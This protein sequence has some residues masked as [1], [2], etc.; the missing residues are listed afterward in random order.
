MSLDFGEIVT[1]ERGV[2]L[3]NMGKKDLLPDKTG[4]CWG[5]G[6]GGLIIACSTCC[7]TT[8]RCGG[9]GRGG[10]II[11]CS[12]CSPTTAGC[13]GVGGGLSVFHVLLN[14]RRVERSCFS[15]TVGCGVGGGGLEN[16]MFHVLLK[17]QGWKGRAS[18]RQRGVVGRGG[19][20]RVFRILQLGISRWRA[21]DHAAWV[22]WAQRL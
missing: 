10:L 12:T 17:Q 6:G 22:L 2:L 20:M 5:G 11:A 15:T 14:N 21:K 19:L 3:S 9:V 8:A 16:C 13:G 4:V 1:S 7:S 18:L